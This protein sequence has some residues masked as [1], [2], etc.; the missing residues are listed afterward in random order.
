[1]PLKLTDIQASSGVIYGCLEC[2]K[3]SPYQHAEASGQ[4]PEE[5][6]IDERDLPN[7]YIPPKKMTDIFPDMGGA[8]QHHE[9]PI[10]LNSLPYTEAT[11]K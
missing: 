7:L 6:D 9:Y 1:V 2:K 5:L 11:Q 4:N 8:E 3:N 10:F